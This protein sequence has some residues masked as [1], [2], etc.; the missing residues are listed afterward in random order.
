MGEVQA[1]Q[2]KYRRAIENFEKF[3]DL[4][5]KDDPDRGEASRLI[6]QLKRK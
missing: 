1:A 3:L 4:A 5:P 6:K 2:K